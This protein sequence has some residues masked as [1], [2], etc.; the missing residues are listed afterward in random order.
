M[1]ERVEM[2]DTKLGSV[3]TMS[4]FESSMYK[5]VGSHQ[6]AT[7]GKQKKPLTVN[8][9][10]RKQNQMLIFNNLQSVKSL[11]TLELEKLRD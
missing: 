4:I 6:N 5:K 2:P 7:G 8:L 1:L 11:T 9:V 3:N 10:I